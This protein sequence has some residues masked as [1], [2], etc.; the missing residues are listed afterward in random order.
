MA[1]GIYKV[2]RVACRLR[3]WF[4]KPDATDKRG[5]FVNAKTSK[6]QARGKKN[7]SRGISIQF[8][9]TCSRSTNLSC[10][11]NAF[12][13]YI[14]WLLGFIT[15]LVGACT[16]LQ[17]STFWTSIYGQS[18]YKCGLSLSQDSVRKAP[19]FEYFFFF[20]QQITGIFFALLGAEG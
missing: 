11:Q 14:H 16:W 15:L 20:L 9:F 3:I 10:T 1:F 17:Y 4:V 7:C 18:L 12:F 8:W 13:A 2:V 6:S 19:Y 5:D